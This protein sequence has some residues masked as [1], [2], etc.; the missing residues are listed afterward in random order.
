MANIYI[1][2]IDDSDTLS[3]YQDWRD[4]FAQA[5]FK[6]VNLRNATKWD[7]VKIGMLGLLN[8]QWIV[9]GHSSYYKLSGA[10]R[11]YL[12]RLLPKLAARKAFF[13]DNEFRL[14]REKIAFAQ[15]TGAEVIVSQFPQ[16][17]AESFYGPHT[18]LHILS[19]PHAL[20]PDVFKPGPHAQLRPID[21][22]SRSHDFAFYLGDRDRQNALCFTQ[23]LQDIPD[24]K[25]DISTDANSRF[26]RAQWAAFLQSCKMTIAS[27]AGSSFIEYDDRT[28]FAVN[29]FLEANPGASFNDVFDRFFA[30]YANPVSGKII[31]PRHFDAAGT[32]TCQILMEGRYNDILLPSVHYIPL[33][34]DLS[35]QA[36]V[37]EMMRNPDLSWR[38]AEQ[39]YNHILSAHTY[40]KRVATFLGLLEGLRPIRADLRRNAS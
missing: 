15:S 26:T 2:A 13:L 29:D 30:N 20:N 32:K 5:G 24:L 40:Q 28:R 25:I 3:Y 17:V 35:N 19:L 34:R 21:V 10:T 23:H 37:I 11:Y 39:A 16:D 1:C 9:L 18:D 27:E 6:I 4:A 7:V 12:S 8:C 22:G 14:F 38:I 36:D 33:K 31:S